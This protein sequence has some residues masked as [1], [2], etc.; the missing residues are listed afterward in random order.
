MAYRKPTKKSLGQHFLQDPYIIDRILQL[1]DPITDDCVVEIG[2]GSGCLTDQMARLVKQLIAVEIDRDCVAHCRSQYA[3]MPHVSVVHADFLEMASTV[4]PESFRPCRWVGN[5]PYNVS[6]P[7]LLKLAEWV[8]WVKDG[9]FLVQKE[10][11]QRCCAGVGEQHY[12]RL[13]IVLQCT[14]TVDP[15][16]SVP[17]E[18]FDPPPKVDSEMFIL[19][20]LIDSKRHYLSHPVF[21][22]VLVR[23][24]SHRRKTMRK[25]FQGL[26]TDADWDSMSIDAQLRPQMIHRDEFYQIACCLDDQIAS[27]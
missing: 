20:P 18:A 2:P 19:R 13:G 7:I 16:L 8:D 9:H 24:F 23:S 27:S 12:G 5:L 3:D 15:V 26:I 11:S 10:V 22:D 17:P 1:V 6:V 14:F 4:L 21:S 25:I